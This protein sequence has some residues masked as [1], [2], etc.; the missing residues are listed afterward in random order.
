MEYS[1]EDLLFKTG[2]IEVLKERLPYVKKYL[3]NISEEEFLCRKEI[4]EEI[5]KI[6]ALDV[7]HNHSWSF[8]HQEDIDTRNKNE[9]SYIYF[10]T[11]D[12][13]ICT[14]MK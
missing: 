14:T 8:P 2:F 3:E 7:R 9:Y 10:L 6:E 13:I 5:L 11:N 12:E 1:D 4:L